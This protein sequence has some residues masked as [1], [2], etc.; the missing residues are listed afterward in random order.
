MTGHEFSIHQQPWP[1]WS[2]ELATDELIT[3]IIQVNGRLRDKIDVESSISQEEAEKI[4]LGRD[5][6]KAHISG[7]NIQR[8][9]YIDGKL[10]NIVAS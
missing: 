9:I 8:V 6:V 3:L 1:E 7:N 4:A 10:I 5:R 2:G